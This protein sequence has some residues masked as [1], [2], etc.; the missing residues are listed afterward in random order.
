M[1]MEM[2]MM[3]EIAKFLLCVRLCVL[4]PAAEAAAGL[5]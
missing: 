5:T 4:L 2:M 1:M 3:M